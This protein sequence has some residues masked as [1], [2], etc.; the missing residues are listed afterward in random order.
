MKSSGSYYA[1]KDAIHNIR[2]N[3]IMS[4]A[5]VVILLSCLLI[6]GS[7][8]LIIFNIDIFVKSLENKSEVVVFVDD[9]FDKTPVEELSAKISE[10]PNVSEATYQS[11]AEAIEEYILSINSTDEAINQKLR[12]DNPLRASFHIKFADLG[13]Y[14]ETMVQIENLDFIAKIRENRS[15]V[16]TILNIKNAVTII[17]FWAIGIFLFLSLF[18]ISNTVRL[19]MFTRKLEINIMKYVGATDGFIRKPFIFEGLFLGTLAGGLAFGIEWLVY[20]KV[21]APMLVSM[22]LFSPLVFGNYWLI[23]LVVFIGAGAIIGIVGSILP[24]RKYL[25]A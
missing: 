16:G 5:S 4:S 21:I 3:T 6:I 17:S 10:I 12:E 13:I 2:K 20:S 25:H 15:A 1:A 9:A 18:I 23:A 7:S 11:K 22:N 24:M 14:S 19:A 8:I